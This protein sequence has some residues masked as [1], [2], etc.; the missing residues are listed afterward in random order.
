MNFPYLRNFFFIFIPAYIVVFTTKLVFLFYLFDNFTNYSLNDLIYSIMWG[1]KFDFAAASIIAFIATF[2][3]FHK[4]SFVLVSAGL[5]TSLFLSQISDIMYFYESSRHMGYEVSD[6]ITDSYGLI[7]TALSQHT[8]LSISSLIIS[9]I[10]FVLIYKYYNLKLSTIIFNKVYILKKLLII[11]VAVFFARGMTQSIPLNPWQSN[12]IGD[13]KLAVLALNGT[14]N[15]IYALS[16]KSKKLEPRKLPSIEQN[17]IQKELHS[18]YNTPYLTFETNLKKPNVVFFFLESWS[19]VNIKSYGYEKTT[20]PFFDS[21]LKKSIRPKAMIAGGHRTTEGIFSTLCSFQNPLGKSISKTQLQNFEYTSLIDIFNKNGYESLFFQGSSKETSGTGSFAQNLGFQQSFGKRDIKKRIYKENYWGVHDPDLYNF[22]L[23]KLNVIQK[24]F[25]IGI[26]G[27]TTHDAKIPKGIKKINFTENNNKNSVLN[28]LHFSDLA[29]KEFVHKI[30]ELYPNTLFVFFADHCAVV[31]GSSFENY[32]I[33]FALYHKQL[34]EKYYDFYISQRD[35]APTVLD[36]V[37]GNYKN[38]TDKFTGKSL[39][40]DKDFVADYYHNGIL[41]WVEKNHAV[42]LNIVTNK[43]KC[44]ELTS[45]K[46]KQI[47]CTKEMI[48]FKDKVLAFTTVSQKLMFSGNTTKFN[49]Y[50][51]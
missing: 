11:L 4:K 12:Q 37:F 30:E 8:I 29:L 38:I 25:V 5:I 45:F 7:M 21:I 20:T 9:I 17:Q 39:F 47:D 36:A 24:P 19:A 28:A 18:V 3:D 41:G 49:K 13:S 16:S 42:E 1:Y 22:T 34:E 35:I 48:N 46:D 32:M 43:Y 15:S 2:F 33:P 27:A 44:F 40:S 51:K 26:N 31:Q 50:N 14:Y 6:A 23:E 10:M